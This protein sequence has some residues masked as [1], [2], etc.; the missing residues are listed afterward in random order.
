MISWIHAGVRREDLG[1]DPAL[2]LTARDS[3][4]AAHCPEALM[5]S[6]QT[7]DHLPPSQFSKPHS[8]CTRRVSR[9]MLFKPVLFKGRL[10]LTVKWHIFKTLGTFYPTAVQNQQ[11]PPAA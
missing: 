9:P 2:L 11:L 8:R 4:Q 6:S 1:S 3:R 10:Y 7:Q 5:A